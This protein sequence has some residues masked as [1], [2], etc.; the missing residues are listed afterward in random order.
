MTGDASAALTPADASWL[1]IT[2]DGLD[3]VSAS[4]A[5]FAMGIACTSG[6]RPANRAQLVL[7]GVYRVAATTLRAADASE[8]VLAACMKTV[9]S[10]GGCQCKC[11]DY[12]PELAEGCVFAALHSGI[13]G[14]IVAAMRRVA[15]SSAVADVGCQVLQHVGQLGTDTTTGAQ[16]MLRA[17]VDAGATDAVLAAMRRHAAS[18]EVQINGCNA[19]ACF[20]RG[21]LENTPAVEAIL[22]AMRRHADDGSV[23]GFG[24]CA[25]WCITCF[26]TPATIDAIA[27][28]GAIEMVL[29]AIRRNPTYHFLHRHG[30]ALLAN[31]SCGS[32]VNRA[33]IIRRGGVKTMLAVIRSDVT[34]IVRAALAVLVN[35][36]VT[37]E[38]WSG[39]S[40]AI[41]SA[42]GVDVVVDAMRRHA[43]AV[44]VQIDAC[45]VVAELTLDAVP[46]GCVDAVT[47]AMRRYRSNPHMQQHGCAALAA[48]AA[49][50]AGQAA[51]GRGGG[52]DAVLGAMLAHPGSKQVQESGCAALLRL[53][54]N[55]ANKAAIVAGGGCRVAAA[56]RPCC[57]PT[58]ERLIAAL[59]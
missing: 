55:A 50:S 19:L 3:A 25:L 29:V 58:A 1:V 33:K 13:V 57:P 41:A 27:A 34:E 59:E 6:C 20:V 37:D 38:G 56:A 42:G 51:V 35:I 5:W 28:G 4:S 14:A 32:G 23:H 40:A 26:D 49:T 31:L 11:D 52:V 47:L 2:A 10:L 30:C 22:E 48:L 44:I 24:S 54:D 9:S 43:D 18:A 53:A 16:P 21:K 17:L 12:D 15:T 45:R 46:R 36:A 8:E 7:A 39:D